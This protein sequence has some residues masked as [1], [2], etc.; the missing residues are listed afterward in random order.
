METLA[1]STSGTHTYIHTGQ[2]YYSQAHVTPQ[3]LHVI[4]AF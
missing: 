1:G 4:V 2:V 3:L